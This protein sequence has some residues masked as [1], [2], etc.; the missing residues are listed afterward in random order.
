MFLEITMEKENRTRLIRIIAGALLLASAFITEK[1]VQLPMWQYL[2]IYLVPYA[3]VGYDVVAEAIENIFHGKVFDEDFLMCI[4]T[5]GALGIGFMPGNEPQFAEAVF[6]MLFF[7]VGEFFEDAAEGKTR[8]SVAALMDLRP[9][10]ANVIR[11]GE[12]ISVSPEEIEVGE[13]IVVRPGERIA[14]DGVVTEGTSSLNT[15]ALTGE[16]LPRDVAPG[17]AVVSGCVN[18]SGVINVRV[19][20]AFD[21]STVSRIL[22]LVENASERKS[23]RE[24]FIDRFSRI[25]TP[26]V[27]FAAVILAVLPP[28]FSGDFAAEFPKYFSR[29]LTFL[30][31]SC[32]CA[33]VISVPLAFFAGI[34]CA[35]SKGVLVKGS[36]YMETL[37]SLGTVVFDK[38]GTLTEGVFAVT[39]VHPE[40]ID[41]ITLLHLA[42]HVERYSTHPIALS[43]RQ[44][45]ANEADSCS[46]ENVREIAGGGVCA[47]INGRTVAVGNEKLMANVGATLCRCEKCASS[48]T[49]VHV[50][51]DGVYAG[52][53]V[54]S[55]KIKNDSAYAIE[56]LRSAGVRR[57]VMLTGDTEEV[58]LR[59]ANE[60]GLDEYH[61]SLLPEDKVE[62]LRDIMDKRDKGE[63]IAFVGDGINDA[64]VLATADVGIA[65]GALGSDAAMEAA[66]VVLMD[67]KPSKIALAINIAKRTLAIARG[68]IVFALAVKAAILILALFGFAPMWLAVFGDVGVTV[69]AVLNSMRALKY[70]IR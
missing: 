17:E 25:Y 44:A 52:H 14:L 8:R 67:D 58:A 56:A 49:V 45:Y 26:A 48:G 68:N 1:N 28:L 5:F 57:T 42:S 31:V 20:K 34:G 46:V 50:A 39:A 36:G 61:A 2:L 43:L 6:V 66:D 62:R 4:A 24:K 23:K 64:P 9:D 35:S 10:T 32:P 37:A 11:N 63:T 59:V 40:Q 60:L 53:I 18:I 13:I 16:S 15:S 33:L 70:R 12:M 30:V 55:D 19:V 29:A 21:E 65:M 41:D 69:L 27:V 47:D 54:I 38:T 51:I 7:Q 3:V 22:D